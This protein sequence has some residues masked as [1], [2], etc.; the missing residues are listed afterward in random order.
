MF[1]LSCSIIALVL[2]FC[3]GLTRSLET[4]EVKRLNIL[5]WDTQVELDE[6]KEELKRIS[7][8]LIKC[9][10]ELAKAKKELNA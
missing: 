5:Y 8:D 10:L 3:V 7:S 1:T 4:P 2:G 9:K 6:T